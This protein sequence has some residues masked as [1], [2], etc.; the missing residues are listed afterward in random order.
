M[1]DDKKDGAVGP[2]SQT[3]Q[4]EIVGPN[5]FPNALKHFEENHAGAVDQD[6]KESENDGA[7]TMVTVTAVPLKKQVLTGVANSVP[8]LCQIETKGLPVGALVRVPLNIAVVLDRSGSMYGPKLDNAKVAVLKM[9]H[10]LHANDT[11]HFVCYG[12]TAVT[13]FENKSPQDKTA[14]VEMVRKVRTEGCTN[15]SGGLQQGAALLHK[16]RQPGFSNRMFLFSD[17]LANEGETSQK[18]IA[19]MVSAL[20]N[21]HQIRVDSFGIGDDFEPTMMKNIAERGSGS[22]YY[23]ESAEI[24][25][26]LVGKALEGLLEL[27][28]QDALLR[29]RGTGAG[30]AKQIYGKGCTSLIQGVRIGDLHQNDVTSQLVE[31]QVCPVQT[32]EQVVLSWE[33]SYLPQPGQAATVLKGTMTVVAVDDATAMVAEEDDQ[34]VKD[35]MVLQEAAESDLR[36]QDLIKKGNAAG[37][38]QEQQLQNDALSAAICSSK[39]PM[40][41][42]WSDIGKRTATQI[43]KEGCSPSSSNRIFTNCYGKGKGSAY[44]KRYKKS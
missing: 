16:Y 22:F 9:I 2:H 24:I 5:S 31:L 23:I 33:L 20:K 11:V 27:V 3:H 14:L 13:I 1:A 19:K 26:E 42:M 30:I 43:Q 25:P 40:L 37:A 28:G 38:L 4:D 12:S 36:I 35:A 21:K 18:D 15:L 44:T 34:N 6:V 8:V 41:A 29:V 39:S 7:K 17:G 10:N 32:G